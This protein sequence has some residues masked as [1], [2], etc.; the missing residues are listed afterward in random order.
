M[1]HPGTDAP[2]TRRLSVV[3]VPAIT[4]RP[5]SAP[6]AA[7]A[8]SMPRDISGGQTV[9]FHPKAP[10]PRRSGHNICC[11]LFACCYCHRLAG[12]LSH[13]V[14]TGFGREALSPFRKN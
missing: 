6:S 14:W 7:Q 13:P 12:R 8:T 11:C 9:R 5:L 2:R 1:M 10:R 4:Q 3:F